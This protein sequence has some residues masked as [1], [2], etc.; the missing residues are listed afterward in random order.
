MAS[1]GETVHKMLAE[2][3]KMTPKKW[4]DSPED[5]EIDKITGAKEGSEEDEKLDKAAVKAVDKGQEEQKK[6]DEKKDVKEETEVVSEDEQIDEISASKLGRYVKGAVDSKADAIADMDYDRHMSR[7]TANL[8]KYRKTIQKRE[9]G[10]KNAMNKLTG[11]EG[12]SRTNP[13][14][15]AREK[16]FVGVRRPKVSSTNE[17]VEDQAVDP[18]QQ[19][20]I[21]EISRGKAKEYLGASR[22]DVTRMYHSTKNDD[23]SVDRYVKR[24]TGI[25]NAKKKIAGDAKVPVSEEVEQINEWTHNISVSANDIDKDKTAKAIQQKLKSAGVETGAIDSKGHKVVFAAKAT[26]PEHGKVIDSLRKNINYG[27]AVSVSH[28]VR[29]STEY[30]ESDLIGLA[31]SAKPIDFADTFNEIMLDRITAVIDARETEIAKTLFA[32]NA[33]EEPVA[34]EVEID[35]DVEQVDEARRPRWSNM[36]HSD[37]KNHAKAAG[38]TVTRHRI[39]GGGNMY[40]AKDANGTVQGQFDDFT[41]SGFYHGKDGRNKNLPKE[42]PIFDSFSPGDRVRRNIGLSNAGNKLTGH[43]KVNVKE[44]VEQITEGLKTAEKIPNGYYVMHRSSGFIHSG[45]HASKLS[46]H[47]VA[48]REPDRHGLKVVPHDELRGEWA[49][50]EKREKQARLAVKGTK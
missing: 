15:G 45:P 37:F 33:D 49:E 42:K 10:I 36:Y 9:A 1:F 50:I 43:A 27:H 31:A 19:A 25:S 7:G 44:D 21:D 17:N 22:D 38:H 47:G 30:D 2:S 34:E 48:G 28:A 40:V 11:G 41:Q 5:K 29:E 35:E 13:N 6:E 18:V 26:S 12:F 20:Y 16:I 24:M 4:E 14:N 8:S 39:S 46:A 23:K 3:A 32:S